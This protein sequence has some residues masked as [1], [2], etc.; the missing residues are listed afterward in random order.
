[1]PLLSTYA[2]ACNAESNASLEEH[3]VMDVLGGNERLRNDV[4][5]PR[6]ATTHHAPPHPTSGYLM[7]PDQKRE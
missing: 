2:E 6:E 1:M 5:P 4:K 7:G 3:L